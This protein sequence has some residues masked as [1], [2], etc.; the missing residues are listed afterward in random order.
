MID[1]AAKCSSEAT[2]DYICEE[3][4][5]SKGASDEVFSASKLAVDAEG[6]KT[7]GTAK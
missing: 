6:K 3:F 5:T 1:M 7:Y 2:C 4:V